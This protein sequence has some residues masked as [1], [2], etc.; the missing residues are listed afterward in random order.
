MSNKEKV[1]L[2]W[3]GGKDSALA[4]Y[5]IISN[6]EYE[7]VGIITCIDP[8]TN[9]A[10]YH[11]IPDSLII[12]QA[13]LLKLPL[14]RIFIPNPCSNDEYSELIKSKLM[15]YKKAGIKTIAFGDS[16]HADIR[17]FRENLLAPLDIKAIFPLWNLSA[18][19]INE[20]FLALGFKALVT[21]VDTTKLD[22][23]YLNREFNEEFLQSLPNEENMEN[24]HTFVLF[25]PGFKSRVAFSKS[26]AV[27][28]GP[29]LVSLVKEP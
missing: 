28:E 26:M 27:I 16:L 19:N 24:F 2:F 9:R 23:S 5:K 14:Q 3:S 11:G 15:I 13:K 29:F 7:L 8:A 22:K 10:P 25:G 12:E 1:M 20:E 21:A 4:L 18:K 6:P 17:Q